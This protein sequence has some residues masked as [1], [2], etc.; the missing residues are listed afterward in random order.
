MFG[1]DRMC[2]ERGRVVKKIFQS[3]SERIKGWKDLNGDG[4]NML[5]RVYG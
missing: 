5:K 2:S 3:K 4:R 1:M